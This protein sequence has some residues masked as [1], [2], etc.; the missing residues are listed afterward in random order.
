MVRHGPSVML[1]DV[2][3]DWGWAELSDDERAVVRR[4]EAVLRADRKA[5]TVLTAEEAQR[6]VTAAYSLRVE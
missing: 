1:H 2:E 5:H 6:A 3:I 4:H